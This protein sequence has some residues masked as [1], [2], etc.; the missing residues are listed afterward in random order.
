M[1][2]EIGQTYFTNLAVFTPQDFLSM[3][4]HFTT[5]YMKGLIS[6][7]NSI[8]MTYSLVN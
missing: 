4:G 1:M 6:N 2:L 5:L 7:S 8:T 3:F